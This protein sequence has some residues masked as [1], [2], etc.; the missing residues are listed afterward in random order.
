MVPA[1]TV[2][3]IGA[4]ETPVPPVAVVN[5]I[6]PV[7]VAV[8]AVAVLPWQYTTGLT[9]VGAVGNALIVTVTSVRG[10]SQPLAVFFAAA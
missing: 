10:P 2:P 6:K 3:G 7:P 1:V 5:H 8:N 4:V 9:T